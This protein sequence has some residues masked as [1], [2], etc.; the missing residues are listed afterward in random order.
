MNNQ[1]IERRLGALEESMGTLDAPQPVIK[2]VLVSP[3]GSR[4]EPMTV[5]EL[6]QRTRERRQAHGG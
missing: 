4:S 3:D 6:R 1:K 2:I 5:E